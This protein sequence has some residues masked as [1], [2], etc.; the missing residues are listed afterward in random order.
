M[1][2]SVT[3][4]T[5]STSSTTSSSSSTSLSASYEMFLTLLTTQLQTQNPLDPVDSTEFTS[6]LATYASLEQQI[7]TNDKLD[8]VLSSMD[9]LSF[10]TGVG[11]IGLTVEAEGDTLSVDSDG[12][13]DGSWK[14][15]LDSAA[16]DVTLTIV[17]SSGN[18][19]WS[20]SGETSAGSH[21]LTWDG[22]DSDGDAV[23]SG[24]Y[25][26][27]V[28]A[29]DADG[30]SIDTTTSI[31]GTVTAV[32]SSSGSTVLEIGDTEID[33]SDVTRLAA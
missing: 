16:E 14:Y 19:V 23:S 5:S 32:D 10:S 12:T 28:T 27:V 6:Q 24:E 21:S 7:E 25:T 26:L 20:G 18:T 11:Y 4:S 8:S 9:S 17:D 29:T 13:V 1:V 31:V 3:S 30:D 15:E 22:T 2:D 33:L